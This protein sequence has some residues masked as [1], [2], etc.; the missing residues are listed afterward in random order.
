MITLSVAAAT[1]TVHACG[2][3]AVINGGFTV[4]HPRSLEVAV[5]VAEARSAGVLPALGSDV[6]SNDV[7]LRQMIA[8]LRRLQSRLNAGRV[9]ID[10]GTSAPFSLVLVGPGL[11]SHFHMTSGGVLARYHVDGPLDGEAVV[12]THQLV[13]EALLRGSLT[14]ED[15]LDQ[16]LLVFSGDDADVVRKAFNS[17]LGPKA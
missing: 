4:S 9:A 2:L 3:E 11:W 15:A 5:A 13:L 17:G 1:D 8:H 10:K 14:A 6:A 12:L 7:L 16:G